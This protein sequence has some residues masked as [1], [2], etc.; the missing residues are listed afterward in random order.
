MFAQDEDFDK[1]MAA[2][3]RDEKIRKV[4]FDLE[5]EDG[6]NLKTKRVESTAKYAARG[7]GV[8]KARTKAGKRFNS[9]SKG[10]KVNVSP[11]ARAR[12]GQQGESTLDWIKRSI[13]AIFR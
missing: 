9:R 12:R 5:N 6:L 2:L 4:K 8:I 3:K 11:P 13:G 1:E 10:K 7:G